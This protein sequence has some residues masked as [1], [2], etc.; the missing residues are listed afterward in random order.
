MYKQAKRIFDVCFSAGVLALLFIPG[1]VLGAAISME[2][3]GGPLFRQQRIGKD[4]RQIHIFKFRSMHSDAHEH[5]ERYLSEK[6]M[7]QWKRE[8]KVDEDPRITKIGRF[9]RKTSLDEVP[10][11]INVLMG[12]MSIIGPRPVTLRETYEF[13]DRR[14]EVLS[15][16]PGITGWWQVTDRNNATWENGRRQELELYYVRNMSAS[17]DVRIVFKTLGAM[18]SGTGR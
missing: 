15:I 10:Q 9:I 6:Q 11:F 5:P 13:G 7:V 12:D 17:L 2:S 14:S 18:F 8:Q 16:R 3:P 4:G 1:I